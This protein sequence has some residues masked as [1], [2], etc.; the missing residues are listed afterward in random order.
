MSSDPSTGL[1]GRLARTARTVARPAPGRSAQRPFYVGWTRYSAFLQDTGGLDLA[2]KDRFPDAD[3]YR[4]HL[5]APDRMAARAHMFLTLSV[6]LL[7]AMSEQHDY[8]HV[9]TYS[10]EMPEP[11][12]S[13][14]LEAARTYD[15]LELRPVAAG[16]PVEALR[17]L[18]LAREQASRPAVWFRVDDDDLLPT[19]YL[20]LVDAHVAHVG[21]GWAV[22][23]GMGY[24][25]LWHEGHVH[26]V[27]RKHRPTG[28]HGQAFSG[29]WDAPTGTLSVPAPGNHRTVDRRSPTVVDSLPLAWIRL[30]HAW[31]DSGA[32]GR[33]SFEELAAPLLR[34]PSRVRDEAD[35]LS[36]WPT[37]EQVYRPD[38]A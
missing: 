31:Q 19:D 29:W 7:Q 32:Q 24:D 1:L 26:H 2:T 21:P 15:V 36:R 14:L 4:A 35:L 34:N 38:S 16:G 30:S 8:R 13:Q 28:S 3:A 25:G 37:L 20:D 5:W 33:P 12:L 6:P 22:C 17:D 23:L 9:V 18:L 10:P 27:R 11:W